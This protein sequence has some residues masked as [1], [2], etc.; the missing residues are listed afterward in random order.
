MVKLINLETKEEFKFNY[1]RAAAQYLINNG[2]T[3]AID[4]DAVLNRI[5]MSAK[6]GARIY[7]KIKAEFIN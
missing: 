1:M 6:S 2:F 3:R 5:S 4:V 7:K